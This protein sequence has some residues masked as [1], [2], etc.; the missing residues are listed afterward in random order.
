[1]AEIWLKNE[2]LDVRIDRETLSLSVI[3]KQ[4]S[5]SWS[6]KNL[7][8]ILYGGHIVVPPSYCKAAFEEAQ[9]RV[10]IKLY[11]FKYWKRWPGHYYQTPENGPDLLVSLELVLRQN[12]LILA[13]DPIENMDEEQLEIAF[14]CELGG[15][16]SC[17]PG[18]LVLPYGAGIIVR[19]PH[20]SS[21]RLD[22][23]VYGFLNMPIFGILRGDHG[24]ACIVE[25][26]FDCRFRTSIN[27]NSKR[28][29]GI[30]PVFVFEQG[31]L[32]YRRSVEYVFM[33]RATHV[34]VA[35]A[36]RRRLIE[37]GRFVSLKQKM[38]ENPEVENLVGA[39]VWKHNVF[40]KERPPGVR[41]DYSL[42][43][44]DPRHA[45]YEGKPANWTAEE[46]FG[47]AKKRGF[48]RVVVYNTGWSAGGFDAGLPTRFPTDKERGT[49]KEF[50]AVADWAKTLSDGY[51]F[52][53]HD[54]FSQAYKKSPEWSTNY[55]VKGRNG[56]FLDKG[57]WAGGKS[58]AICS[59]E[60]LKF[61]QRDI[62]RIAEMV[63]KGSLYVDVMGGKTPLYECFDGA[64]PMT[65]QTDAALREDVFRLAKRYFGT[66]ATESTPKGF[67]AGVVDMGAFIRVHF[68]DY[69]FGGSQRPIP[70]PLF[71]LVYHDSVLNFLTESRQMFYSD[72]YLLYV[73]LYNTLPFSL[74]NM[75]KYLSFALRETYV[76]EMIEHQFM[77]DSRV[78]ASTDGTYWT[79][80]VQKTLFEDGTTIIANF[81]GEEFAY[82]NNTIKAR[83]FAVLRDGK[84]VSNDFV[85]GR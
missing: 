85:S 59:A 61:A 74:E 52:S 73:A 6:C 20:G 69:S 75:S 63:G 79:N 64:H 33:Q 70:I 78:V 65:R 25:T 9:D 13:I 67:L 24:L 39:V 36:Y 34:D 31:R 49:E 21:G 1:M 32:N 18:E 54:N 22:H 66:V 77:S 16:R 41:K 35:K 23:W 28:E 29:V 48:D 5:F 40:C 12:S 3:E 57:I 4:S 2:R 50:R 51:I 44:M 38:A 76:S 27:Q 37:G 43:M 15:F 71:Q 19:F 14:P 11:N 7:F 30:S 81:S 68:F 55:L 46:I 58:Y 42:Y 26:P 72:E 84:V 82:Q 10:T 8:Q 60:S 45:V 80:G 56:E 62:P 47:T 17:E 83:E 53:V